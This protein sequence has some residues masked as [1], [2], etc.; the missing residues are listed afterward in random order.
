M[1]IAAAPLPTADPSFRWPALALLGAGLVFLAGC[2]TKPQDPNASA[3]REDVAELHQIVVDAQQLV[4]ATLQSLDRTATRTPCP[5]REWRT[6]AR[7]IQRLEVDSFKVRA[8]AQAIRTR[9]QAYFEQWQ[10]RLANVQDPEVRRLAEQR[11]EHLQERFSRIRLHAEQARAALQPFMAGLRRLRN[12][13]ENDPAATGT[14]S[15]KELI[16]N[17]RDNGQKVE[18]DLTAIRE[19]LDAVA[20]MLKPSKGAKKD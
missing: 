12:E 16:R 9:G 6:F 18:A 19:E 20:A 3:P 2:V 13:L 5:A 15:M 14:D 17:T 11:R 8:R 7:D 4:R 1:G 10:E